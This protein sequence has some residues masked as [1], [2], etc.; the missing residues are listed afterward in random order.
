M[1]LGELG[2]S[3]AMKGQQLLQ[4]LAACPVALE[5]DLLLSLKPSVALELLL[6]KSGLLRPSRPPH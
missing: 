5:V 2:V 1:A 4:G 6:P 3:W